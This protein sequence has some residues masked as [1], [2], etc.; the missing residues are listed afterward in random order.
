MNKILAILYALYVVLYVTGCA[1]R[2]STDYELH[3]FMNRGAEV[4][5]GY[6]T[7]EEGTTKFTIHRGEPQEE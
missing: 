7:N 1:I 5:T 4:A 2:Q 3:L 6:Y